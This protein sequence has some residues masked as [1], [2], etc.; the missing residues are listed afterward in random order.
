MLGIASVNE[1]VMLPVVLDGFQDLHPRR[2]CYLLGEIV[3][4]VLQLV[5]AKKPPPFRALQEQVEFFLLLGALISSRSGNRPAL[6][7]KRQNVI[8]AGDD[9]P[10]AAWKP[11]EAF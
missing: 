2:I 5:V 3:Y 11:S 10:S 6:R 4:D 1:S 9:E 7:L 8:P